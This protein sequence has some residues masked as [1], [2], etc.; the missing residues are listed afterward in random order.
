MKERIQIL[1]KAF[2][3]I[4][5]NI[6][7]KRFEAIETNMQPGLVIAI[8]GA[9]DKSYHGK[10]LNKIFDLAGGKGINITVVPW[11]SG[12]KDAGE[13][14][15]KIFLHLGAKN[16]FLLKDKNRKSFLEAIDRSALLFFTGGDQKNLLDALD[17]LDLIKEIKNGND[18]GLVIAG[19]SA[20]ASILG[21]HMPYYSDEEESTIYFK[22]LNLVP[23]SIIDQHFSQRHRI[24]RLQSGVKRFKEATGYGIDEDSC[25]GFLD[26]KEIFRIGSGSVINGSD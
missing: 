11:A 18:K 21:E 9:E 17:D 15:K 24:N 12:K 8:G 14:Y 4:G 7:S 19:T 13:I 20:G 2:L 10:I 1:K 6:E 26:G 3:R 23:N 25:I 16:I 22:G 5:K